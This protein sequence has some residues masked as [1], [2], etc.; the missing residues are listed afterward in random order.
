MTAVL[1]GLLAALGWGIADYLAGG[2]A[3]LVGLRRTAFFTQAAGFVAVSLLLLASP[4]LRASAS[5]A[6]LSAWVYGLAA[7]SCNVVGALALIR[8]FTI[9][10][11]ALVA[12]LITSYAVVTALLGLTTGQ[13][14][15]GLSL[16]G[17]IVCLVGAPLAAAK[18]D[19]DAKSARNDGVR[20]ALAAA[21]CFGVGLWLQG[22]FIIPQLGAAVTLWLF[23]GLGALV[24][25]P[26]LALRGESLLPPR[27]ALPI[28]CLQ[29]LGNLVG[30]GSIAVGMATGAVTVVAVLSTFAAA[31]T[32]VLGLSLQR[33]RLSLPQWL[34]LSAVILGVVLLR[35]GG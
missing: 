3:R 11:A 30:Y 6:P 26:V 10:P 15:R 7:V 31:V 34:G 14:L 5:G 9:G 16:L 22:T 23:F 4:A 21:L 19:S 13:T 25:V 33:E 35:A 29:S 27:E 8:A 1:M 18:H 28:L 2:A 12:P 17:V 24:M 32:A 20:Y